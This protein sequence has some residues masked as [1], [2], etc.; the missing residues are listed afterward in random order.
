MTD[1]R[2]VSRHAAHTLSVVVV[3]G[4][5]GRSAPCSAEAE[6]EAKIWTDEYAETL[7]FGGFKGGNEQRGAPRHKNGTCDV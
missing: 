7:R 3:G 1:S 4:S 2:Q 6:A 5:G